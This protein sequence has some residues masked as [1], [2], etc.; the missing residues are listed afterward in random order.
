MCFYFCVIHRTSSCW[1]KLTWNKKNPSSTLLVYKK[2]ILYKKSKIRQEQGGIMT[3]W[4]FKIFKY[5]F[6][7]I[8]I[9]P[10][11]QET[12]TRKTT[13]HT[14]ITLFLLYIYSNLGENLTREW[15]LKERSKGGVPLVRSTPAYF[16]ITEQ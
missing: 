10:F 1:L 15:E 16:R 7:K 3:K 4:C 2:I 13:L 11:L 12:N 8:I 5:I 6:F 14:L 9:L